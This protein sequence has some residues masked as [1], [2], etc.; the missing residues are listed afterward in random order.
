MSVEKLIKTA[1]DLRIDIVRMIGEAGSGHPG[2]S[3]SCADVLTALYFG[4][5]LEFDID[6]PDAPRDRFILAKG[7]AAPALYAALAHAGFF[8]CEKLLSLRK[9]GSMLQGHPDSNLVPGVEV[10]TGSLGQGLS[11][12]SGLAAGLRLDGDDHAVFALLGDGECQEGQV[13]EAVMFAA[14]QSLDN[15]IAIVDRNCLQIDGNTAD[16]CDPGDLG[17]KFA[18]FGWDVHEVDGHDIETLIVTLNAAKA[19]RTGKPQAIIAHTVKGKGVSFMENEAGWHGKAPNAEQL[20]QALEELGYNP[21]A[22]EEGPAAPS[23]AATSEGAAVMP[24]LSEPRSGEFAGMPRRSEE[25]LAS[26]GAAGPSSS[27][28]K[29]QVDQSLPKKAT[30]SAYGVT[31]AQL[32][33]EGLPIVAVE[34]DLSGSTT[35]AKFAAAKPEYA[36]RLFNCGIAEQN[37]TDVA[38]GL[39]IAG[40]IAFTGSFAVFGTGRA[41]DQI[42]NT[43]CYSNLNVKI[44]P[45]HAGIS[46]G[47][48]GGSHQMLEDIS[49]MRGLPNMRVLVPADYASAAAA[50]RLAAH[51]P[52]PLYVRMGRESV[53]CVYADDIDLILGGSFMLRE[54]ADATIVACGLEVREALLAVDQLAGEGISV[55]LIDAYSVKPLDVASIVASVEKTGCVV[56]AEEHSVYG[57][58]GS[59]VAEALAAERPVPVEFIGMHDR[60]GKSGS[61]AELSVHFKMDA[62]AIADAVKR[63][64]ARK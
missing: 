40:N 43:V 13:W 31:L 33:D 47:P 22:E 57:G 45:T 6:N 55:E 20:A 25:R 1:N 27:A 19:A 4:G 48:D 21:S 58:L 64:I 9:L 24:A 32:A 17:V 61:Y 28:P 62:S 2:G 26:A 12:A 60:F 11:I 56:T 8:P 16:V 41:Y 5:V 36:K 7:H 30:R 37:M 10:S 59:A 54:G 42:R 34:A 49:L 51:T 14:H 29:L 38:A 46:V 63:V 44:A 3:L 23:E 35:T 39:S 50:I 53:P 18:A 52:G 15:L